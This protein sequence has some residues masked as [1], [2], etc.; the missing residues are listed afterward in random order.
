MKVHNV[1]QGS[2]EWLAL[3][4]KCL[5]ASEAPVMMSA[6]TKMMRNELLR[7][8]ATGAEREYSDWVQRNLFDKGHE[9]EAAAR[10]IVEEMI[11][12]ELFPT[13]ATDDEER[14]LASFDGI[15]MLGEVI[16]EHKMWNETLAQA[17]R[18]RNLPPEYFWQLEQQLLVSKAEKAIFVVSDGTREKFVWMEYTPVDGRAALLLAGWAQFENDLAT[19]EVV[20]EKPQAVG[21]SPENLPALRIEVTGMVTDSNLQAFREHAL[22]V[23]GAINRDLVTDQHFADAEKTVKWC[24]DVEDRLA[25][26]KRH[27]LAQTT[28]IDELFRTLD[29]IGEETRSTRLELDRLVKAMKENRRNEILA[30]GKKAFADHIA[31]LNKRLGTVRMPEVSC[32]IATAMKGKRTI[33]TLQDAADSTVAAAKI[34]ASM[35]ADKIDENLETLRTEA[36]EYSFLFTDAQ[37]LVMKENADLVL[38]INARISHHKKM[39]EERIE[40]DRAKIREEEAE[41][42]RLAAAPAPVAQPAAAPAPAQSQA[43]PV[44]QAYRPAPAPAAQHEYHDAPDL[45]IGNICGRLGFTMTAGFLEG[46]GFEPAGRER[47]AVLYHESDFDRICV[48]LI[49]HIESVRVEHHEMA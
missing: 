31:A 26:A 10:V 47:G 12:E 19:Y 28:S 40:R 16:F 33:A 20:D 43:A 21:R 29:A 22:S 30:A 42:A 37:Q 27:A 38:V 9:Y 4:F 11:G 2:P 7:M 41:K 3:R 23:I 34:E 48:A 45:R 46:I 17:V 49:N 35:I 8:K 39:E 14:I 15:T 13:T 1:I 44:R 6:T 18:E 25:A 24:K 36:D 5:T 32:D